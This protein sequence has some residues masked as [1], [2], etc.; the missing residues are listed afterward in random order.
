MGG[1]RPEECSL[2]LVDVQL[3]AE[4]TADLAHYLVIGKA[5]AAQIDT[6]KELIIDI[7]V[8]LLYQTFV[9]T[10]GIVLQEHQ[11]QFPLGTE[12]G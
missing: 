8:E 1:P 6:A 3:L 7:A 10:T 4:F 11:C 12:Y 5:V 2:Y 9:G